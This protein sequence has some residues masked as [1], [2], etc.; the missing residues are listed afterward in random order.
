MFFSEMLHNSNS[1]P[2]K[3]FN[4]LIEGFSF[5]ENKYICWNEFVTV[6]NV[7]FFTFYRCKMYSNYLYIFVTTYNMI[8]I[9]IITST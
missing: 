4:K 3:S 2:N 5:R 9:V 8:I 6:K 7:A 1:F